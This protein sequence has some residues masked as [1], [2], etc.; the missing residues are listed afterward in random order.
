MLSV[1]HEG[2][3]LDFKYKKQ[4]EFTYAFYIGD[5]LIGQVFRMGDQKWSAVGWHNP[6][7]DMHRLYPVDG[8]RS[9]YHASEFMLKMAGYN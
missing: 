3:V 1:V 7:S 2:R 8:F 5:I 4:N 6:E 9:R